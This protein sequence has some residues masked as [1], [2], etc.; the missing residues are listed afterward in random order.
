MKEITIYAGSTIETAW[1]EI[2]IESSKCEDTCFVN[3][4][5]KQILSTDTLD[6]AYKKVTGKTKAEV[7]E[8]QRKW[9][10]DYERKQNEFEMKIPKLTEEYRNRARGLIIESQL[11]YWDEIVP[12]RLGDLY[13]GM[14][15]E[16]TLK[17]CEC[18]ND[19]SMSYD[20]RL[21]KAYNM[22]M[23][24]GHSGMSAS[25]TASMYRRFVPNGNDLA[26]AVLNFRF[27]EK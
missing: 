3:F 1:K 23:D 2:L 6:E 21:R 7:E 9:H 19:E 10:E 27:E 26:D 15:L 8:E 20:M 24:A 18:M 25:L 22:F 17:A 5:G 13:H 11:E 14:E 4:N 16:E 12:V